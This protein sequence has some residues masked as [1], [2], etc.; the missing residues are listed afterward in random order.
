MDD[1]LSLDEQ[2][3]SLPSDQNDHQPKRGGWGG[4]GG[5]RIEGRDGVRARKALFP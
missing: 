2:G 4:S 3:Q 5:G 1:N